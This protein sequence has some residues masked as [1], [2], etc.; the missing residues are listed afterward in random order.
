MTEK[1]RYMEAA[2]PDIDAEDTCTEH[3]HDAPTFALARAFAIAFQETEEPTAEQVA[4]FLD[5]AGA[6]VGDFDPAPLVW[7]VT[8]TE[9][10]REV[11]LEATF[12]ING[13]DYVIQENNSGGHVV[14][15]PLSRTTWDEWVAEAEDDE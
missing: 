6:V 5:D 7:T 10:T 2:Y 3:R 14:C 15:H 12:T 11:G 13:I 8:Q 9:L 1:C 4:W